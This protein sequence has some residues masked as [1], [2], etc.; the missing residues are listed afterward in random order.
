MVA[1]D[2]G[3]LCFQAK[4]KGFIEKGSVWVDGTHF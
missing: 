3:V 2:T 1:L 4:K